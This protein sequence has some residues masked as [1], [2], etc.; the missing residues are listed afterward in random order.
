MSAIAARTSAHSHRE[1][2]KLMSALSLG[3]IAAA[4]LRGYIGGP[5]PATSVPAA[6]LFAG[7]L[8][9]LVRASGWRPPRWRM[10]ARDAALGIAGAALLL[11]AWLAGG[12][13]VLLDAPRHLTAL[14]W[15]SPVVTLVAV[16]EEIAL[17]GALFAAL[18]RWKGGAA[19]VVVTSLLFALI[20]VPLY[21]W[22]AVPVDAAVG[23]VL[24]GLRLLSGGVAAPAMA[25]AL[26][27][28]AAGWLG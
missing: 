16:S 1:M 14:A 10:R 18:L 27:D 13:R 21:G 19:A 5:D 22:Q 24:G 20:H 4:L 25:H 26:T 17:R 7:V 12:E 8:L 15:W 3:I 6:L 9:V 2:A 23:V 28:L 11:A